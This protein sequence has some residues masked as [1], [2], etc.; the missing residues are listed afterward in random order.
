MKDTIIVG[1][2]G[3]GRVA[4]DCLLAGGLADDVAGFVHATTDA[5]GATATL[6]GLP[7]LG[8][9]TDLD[10][11]RS[12][13]ITQAL[14]A[15]GENAL[16]ESLCEHLTRAGIELIS[17]VHPTAAITRGVCLGKN[18]IV[19]PCVAVGVGA[20]IGGGALLNTSCSVDHDCTIGECAHVCPG[21]H[22]AGNVH[23]GARAW[24]GI[25]SSVIQGVTIG[26]D[27]FVGAGS[28]VLKDLPA[29][30]LAYGAPARVIRELA[31]DE[32]G[33]ILT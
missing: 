4:Y 6:D 20:Q 12:E 16:R 2:C 10:R 1:V 28:V 8:T 27:T 29:G 22:L 23:V 14:A 7:V 33:R 26:E 31:D 32:R 24:I 18:V 5:G 13:G 15:V 9:L 21:T 3:T 19:C 11:L 30:V 17:A 25:G